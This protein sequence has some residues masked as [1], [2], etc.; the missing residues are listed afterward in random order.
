MD[1]LNLFN[2]IKNE[3][4]EKRVQNWIQFLTINKFDF[5]NVKEINFLNEAAIITDQNG[6]K[7]SI[8]FVNNKKNYH[9]KKGTI[10]TEIIGRALG[11]G[12]LGLQVLDLGSGLGI[13]ALFLAQLGFNVISLERNPLIFLALQEAAEALPPNLPVQFIFDSAL[14]FFKS[15][16]KHFDLIYFDPMFPEKIK[17]ALPRQEMVFF[18]SLVGEDLD[19]GEVLSLAQKQVGV[20]RVVVKRPLK[21]PILSGQPHSQVKGKL[22]RFDLYGVHQ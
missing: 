7:F 3:K 10:K 2:Y 5:S 21:A 22:I 4:S 1:A 18:R 19:A 16:E 11:A 12:K 15:N 8:D 14:H 13:D 6:N 9:K 17:S 20:Q